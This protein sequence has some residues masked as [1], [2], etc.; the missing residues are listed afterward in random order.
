MKLSGRVKQWIFCLLISVLL[1]GCVM[2]LAYNTLDFW[3]SYYLTDYV[4]LNSDQER[5]FEADLDKALLIHRDRELPK[6]HRLISELQSDL[7]KPLTF[8]QTRGYHFKLTKVGQDSIGL[9]AIPLAEMIRG[10]DEDQIVELNRN[11]KKRIDDAI[12]ERTILTTKQKVTKRTRQLQEIANDWVGT[13]TYKQKQLLHELAGYQVEMEP[14]F[15]SFYRSFLQNWRELIKKRFEPDFDKNLTQMLQKFV[16]LE[17]EPL[18]IDINV[19]LNRRFD[20]MRRLNNSLNDKQR[21]YLDRKL[22]GI[23]IDLA[24]L[25]HQ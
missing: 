22:S 19:Y 2:R 17:N 14:I 5:N 7:K 6:L 3:I 12:A 13:L 23:R 1:T 8:S 21:R 4:S 10:L 16:A 20:V 15:F 9:L 24:I 11:I 18:Q 25:I